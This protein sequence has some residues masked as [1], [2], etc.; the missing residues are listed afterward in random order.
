MAGYSST[1]LV[2]KLGI[3]AGFRVALLNAPNNFLKNL[4]SLPE[5]VKITARLCKDLRRG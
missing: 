2:K 5:N 4:G 1:P 3:N